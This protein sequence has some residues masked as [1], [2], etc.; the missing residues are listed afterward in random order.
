MQESGYSPEY[1]EHNEQTLDKSAL[2]DFFE[3]YQQNNGDT[4][5]NINS[6]FKKEESVIK[7]LAKTEN[8]VIVGRLAN[9]ILRNK[10]HIYNVFITADEE[11]EIEKVKERDHLSHENAAKQVRKVNRERSA[12]CKYFTNTDWG[13]AKNY[14][15]TIKSND[16]GYEKTADLIEI[17]FKQKF[18]L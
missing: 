9:Y 2:N 4:V 15:L 13:N 1:I 11:S 7:H 18:S 6:L 16:F 14:N 8:C 17:L 10:K 3:W 5:P 12:H